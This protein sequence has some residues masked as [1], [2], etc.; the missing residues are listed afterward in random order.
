MTNEKC[1]MKN[2]KWLV[3]FGD[4]RRVGRVLDVGGVDRFVA[5]RLGLRFQWQRSPRAR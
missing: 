2:E 3:F 4:R 1:A 5:E